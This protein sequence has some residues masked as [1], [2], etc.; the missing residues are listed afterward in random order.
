MGP[1]LSIFAKLCAVPGASIP[2]RT[3]FMGSD[4]GGDPWPHKENQ[5]DLLHH[6]NNDKTGNITGNLEN[7]HDFLSGITGHVTRGSTRLGHRPDLPTT[8]DS[9]TNQAAP[10]PSKVAGTQKPLHPREWAG[11]YEGPLEGHA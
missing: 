5:V 1:H 3:L 2:H 10:K 4:K 6:E 11:G 7:T 9:A 8:E